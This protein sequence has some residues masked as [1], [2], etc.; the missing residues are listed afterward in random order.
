MTRN[1]YSRGIPRNKRKCSRNSIKQ[2]QKEARNPSQSIYCVITNRW[3][4][5]ISK[6][7]LLVVSIQQRHSSVQISYRWGKLICPRIHE[8]T[9]S[10]AFYENVVLLAKTLTLSQSKNIFGFSESYVNIS[11]RGHFPADGTV[12]M[13]ECIISLLFKL[14]LHSRIRSLRSLGN[15][16]ISLV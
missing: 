1:T 16:M 10:G 4:K 9:G 5:R 7:S 3:V 2:N 12:I 14:L 13:L 8:L 6:I 11:C 15:R